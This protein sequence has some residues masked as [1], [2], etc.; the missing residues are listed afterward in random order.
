M[1]PAFL[2]ISHSPAPN[3]YLS[4]RI[5]PKA[6]RAFGPIAG[7]NRLRLAVESLNHEFQLRDCPD[8]TKFAFNDQLQ[9]FENASTA[10]CIRYELGTCPAPCAAYCS[11]AE[12]QQRVKQMLDFLTGRDSTILNRLK[13]K[14]IAA[15]GRRAFERAASLRDSLN[16]LAWLDRRLSGLRLAETTLN[17]VLQVEARKGRVAW[18][19]LRHGKLI[20]SVAGH[21]EQHDRAAKTLD[22]LTGISKRQADP[23][24]QLLDISL[25]LLIIS[26]F[27][28]HPHYKQQ[29]ISFED[30]MNSCRQ[31]LRHDPK[32]DAKGGFIG[33]FG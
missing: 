25:Q 16:Q 1:K 22:L 24:T 19:I 3:A 10:K 13:K 33:G 20:Q 14:M 4:R 29:I 9:L 18:L 17:G 2:C 21:A 5:L 6:G 7:T 32:S 15:S 30:A 8:K 11:S 12:Y 26:W 27:K 31:C 28:K 23:P